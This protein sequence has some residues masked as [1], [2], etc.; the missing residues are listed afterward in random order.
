MTQP[1]AP[2]PEETPRLPGMKGPKPPRLAFDGH[3]RALLRRFLSDWV[4]PRR[5][6][7]L[8]SLLFT[9]VLAATTGAYPLVIKHSFDTLLKGDISGSGLPLVLGAI[10]GITALRSVFLYLQTTTT[11]RIV[12]RMSTD[13]QRTA[14]SHLLQADYARLSRDTPGRLMSKLT[15]DVAF[16]QHAVQA[17][18]N[19]VVRDLLS[20]VALV[21]SMFFSIRL[22]RWSC[23]AAIRLR[24]HS[25]SP[26]RAA[27]GA[28]R[29]RRNTNSAA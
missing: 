19:T 5:K 15:N 12:L 11:L 21:G 27:S 8:L 29:Q 18:I 25:S 14:F 3:S 16:I 20:V 13:I 9:T 17:S 24:R 2:P 1:S 6:E 26:Y 7:I 23:S 4:W 10:V 22:S 28:L